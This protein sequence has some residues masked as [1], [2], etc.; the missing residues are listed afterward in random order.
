MFLSKNLLLTLFFYLLSQ[1]NT[2]SQK[3]E[4]SV[5]TGHTEVINDV[6]FSSDNTFFATASADKT[7]ILW[8]VNTGR[9]ISILSGHNGSVNSILFHPVT[10]QLL[11]VSDDGDLII[12]DCEEG[13]IVKKIKISK[14]PLKKVVL[15]PAE[16]KLFI[17]SNNIYCYSLNT[18]KPDELNYSGNDV[19][20]FLDILPSKKAIAFSKGSS[21]EFI[22]YDY[23]QNKELK[24]YNDKGI[25][26]AYK[27]SAL[28]FNTETTQLL[29]GNGDG[30]IKNWNWE[31]KKS[32]NLNATRESYNKN[33]R[34][35]SAI[36]AYKEGYYVANKEMLIYCYDNDGKV[37][38]VLNGHTKSI[39][40]LSLNKQGSLLL[41]AGED[42]RVYLWNTITG[43]LITT[44]EGATNG[45]SDIIHTKDGNGLVFAYTVGEIK[46][47]NLRTNTFTYFSLSS[48]KRDWNYN[49]LKIDSISDT[50]V[51]LDAAFFKKFKKATCIKEI[52]YYKVEWNMKNNSAHL[53]DYKKEIFELGD[54]IK[55]P[56]NSGNSIVKKTNSKDSSAA[57]VRDKYILL[58]KKNN[59]E[60][61]TLIKT[62][63]NIT[64]IAYNSHYNY[65]TSV[66]ND[67]T[68]QCW[69]TDGSLLGTMRAFDEKDFMYVSKDNYYY[70]S[71][72]ALKYVG[73]RIQNKIFSFDQFDMKYNRPDLALN[74]FPFI[75]TLL[76]SSYN[77]A[78]NKRL[79]KNNLN[80]NDLKIEKNVPS[81]TLDLPT[82]LYTNNNEFEFLLHASDSVSQ[83]SGLFININGVPVG[84]KAGESISSNKIDKKISLK[85]APGE[86]LVQVYVNNKNEV[87][88]LKKSFKVEYKTKYQKPN[89]YL[90]CIGAGHYDQKDYNLE[91]AEK[92]A[93]DVIALFAKSKLY[94][95]VYTKILVNESAKKD[96]LKVVRNFV[97]KA[98]YND[99]VIVFIAGH[100]I[101]NKN[102]DYFLSTRDVDFNKPEEKGIPYDDLDGIL[103]NIRSRKKVLLIDACHSGEIDKE[104]VDVMP[105]TAFAKTD[106]KLVFRAAGTNV[107]KKGDMN[108]KS[109]FELSK[110]LFA[111]MR[112]NNGT[113]I[114]SSAG[115]AEYALESKEWKNGAFTYCFLNGLK[116]KKADLNGDRQVL[117]SELQ[118]YLSIT[119]SE[120]TNGKQVSTSRIENLQNDF[121][122]W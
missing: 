2:Y 5:Q 103:D 39:K 43:K 4:L 10:K 45:I 28:N 56:S 70:T 105:D 49:I 22:V 55:T 3:P 32:L 44:I 15:D 114:I 26:K 18:N 62:K 14:A 63:Q 115:G 59:P 33:K 80:E 34:A 19:I 116:N 20:N 100:G 25:F 1:A 113:T 48:Q 42:M 30:F 38:Y 99:V 112:V 85:L 98:D 73:F 83:L 71:K 109:S 57:S 121:R 102:L 88:S 66:G 8:D 47:W 61:Y 91:Y 74:D 97:E 35:I 36:T 6:K 52:I 119:V 94:K 104:D 23:S 106:E 51:Y 122:I 37:R 79:K 92:D 11:S 7:I 86:N 67:G 40:C 27:L 117:L 108:L 46:H 13:T 110:V 31:S 21:G 107:K 9:Q 29:S 82:D 60:P 120:L 90:V 111:D 101:L 72:G 84:S 16:N 50:K 58:Y 54:N 76:L 118:E 24:N 96:S 89:L 64:C 95:N 93:S 41:S 68:L 81:L 53:K 65:I 87:N 69:K 75:D 12:W 78:Y 17:A 77:S